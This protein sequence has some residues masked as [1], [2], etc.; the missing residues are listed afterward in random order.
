[1]SK[2]VTV[3]TSQVADLEVGM[4]LLITD[5]AI[6]QAAK[7]KQRGLLNWIET[8]VLFAF[9]EKLNADRTTIRDESVWTEYQRD[10]SMRS[11]EFIIL[12]NTYP[13]TSDAALATWVSTRYDEL[14]RSQNQ[15]SIP[16]FI[17]NKIKGIKVKEL[18]EPPFEGASY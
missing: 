11:T 4:R 17:W 10:A 2:L 6:R 15:V 7:D 16:R 1:M 5:K 13:D 12:A 3:E 14:V 18:Q 8:Q 9:S